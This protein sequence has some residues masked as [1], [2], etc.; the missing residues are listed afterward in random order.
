MS[1]SYS[2]KHWEHGPGAPVGL[3]SYAFV[4]TPSE[5]LI[6]VKSGEEERGKENYDTLNKSVLWSDEYTRTIHKFIITTLKFL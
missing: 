4:E 5:L 1:N 2:T 3:A 6:K